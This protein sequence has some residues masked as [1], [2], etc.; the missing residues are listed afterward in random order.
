M[1]MKL[2]T[3][4]L[5]CAFAPLASA[6]VAEASISAGQS[7]FRN[8]GLGTDGQYV[9]RIKDGF[10]I[11]GRLTLNTYRFFG[12]EFGYAYSRSK[13]ADT[14]NAFNVGMPTHQ[15]FYNFLAYAFPEGSPVRPFVAGGGHFSTFY[16][17]G[18]SA[19]YGNGVTKFGLNYGAGIKVKVSSM[20]YIRVDVRDYF[21]PKPFDLIDKSG[22]LHQIEA[23]AGFGIVF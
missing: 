23:S 12:H 3:A 7:L 2:R 6:Q 1:N 5:L 19:S 11:G 9:Y 10:R 14:T 21:T 18:T 17:P 13:L 22:L 8:S 15:G 20:Y 4:L 16:P